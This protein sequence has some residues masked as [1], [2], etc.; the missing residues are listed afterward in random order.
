MS[1]GYPMVLDV[2]AR[3]IVIIGGGN[4]ALRKAKG[5]IDSGAGDITVVSPA[6]HPDFPTT[7]L[8]R[9]TDRYRTGHL[10]KAALVF[11]ATD[12]PEVNE[13]VVKDAHAIG[14]L[15]CRADV[16]EDHAGDFSTPAMVRRGPMLITVSSGGS[17]A[18]SAKVRDE[19]AG[20]LD[21]RWVAMA[22]AMRTLRPM[23]RQ[24]LSPAR[25]MEAFR[26]L[27]TEEALAEL[28]R[29]G[30][31]GLKRWLGGSFVELKD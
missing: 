2:R 19:L 20:A 15:V 30:I 6:F 5:L 11:A 21:A 27:C 16:D 10:G 22:E 26:K 18:L 9:V 3:R 8:S 24:S 29:D 17:P 13:Q 1:D 28:S 14:A 31:D 12:S 25:R 7:G 23:I 4:V